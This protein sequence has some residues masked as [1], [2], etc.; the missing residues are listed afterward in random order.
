MFVPGTHNGQIRSSPIFL[1][2]VADCSLGSQILFVIPMSVFIAC[3]CTFGGVGMLCSCAG[4]FPR[5][6]G[7][8]Q[9]WAGLAPSSQTVGSLLRTPLASKAAGKMIVVIQIFIYLQTYIFN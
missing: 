3:K 4:A 1:L 6:V 9:A 7:G 5:K 2:L 8:I